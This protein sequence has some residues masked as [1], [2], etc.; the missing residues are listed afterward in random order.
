MWNDGSQDIN[1]ARER[2]FSPEFFKPALDGGARIVRHQNTIESAHNI[3]RRFAENDSPP[4][5]IQR[6][7]VIE[8]KDIVNTTVGKVI[9]R[10]FNEQISQH[11]T[12]LREVREDMERGL[13]GKNEETRRKLAEEVRRLEERMAEIARDKKRMSADYVTEK[14]RI[15]AAIKVREAPKIVRDEANHARSLRDETDVADRVSSTQQTKRPQDLTPAH[16]NTPPRTSET[17]FPPPS[18][19]STTSS[20]PST[21]Y[22]DPYVQV[23]LPLATHDG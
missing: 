8:R 3:I 1:E 2:D 22:A 7:L 5:Q 18:L 12:E 6:E 4:L 13:K 23:L 14:G 20:S 11:Q 17:G 19:P 9:S 21:I 10:E 16:H 15:E